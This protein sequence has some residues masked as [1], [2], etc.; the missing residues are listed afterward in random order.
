MAR[1]YPD[2]FYGDTG[3]YNYRVGGKFSKPTRGD[4]DSVVKKVYRFAGED[5][6]ERLQ[7]AIRRYARE[8]TQQYLY[9][10]TPNVPQDTKNL[11]DG[12]FVIGWLPATAEQFIA[13]GPRSFANKMQHWGFTDYFSAGKGFVRDL[14]GTV[15]NDGDFADPMGVE[16]EDKISGGGMSEEVAISL[17]SIAPYA[18]LVEEGNAKCP[19]Y[20]GWFT[21]LVSKF[22]NGLNVRTGAIGLP[23]DASDTYTA[24][25]RQ[26]NIL[27]F[28]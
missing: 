28:E 21:A 1:R 8:F 7:N 23:F 15:V 3:R 24:L 14:W 20:K 2:I 16:A 17:L 6:A 10:G 27:P 19:Y 26:L 12:T 11:L 9:E 18:S 4:R 22:V 13:L 5:I 25:A